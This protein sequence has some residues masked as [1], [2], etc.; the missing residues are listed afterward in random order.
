MYTMYHHRETI[1]S[2]LKHTEI[3]KENGYLLTDT[4]SFSLNKP[5]FSHGGPNQRQTS[6]SGPPMVMIDIEPVA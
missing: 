3:N 1:K 4:K 5:I 6:A 2:T